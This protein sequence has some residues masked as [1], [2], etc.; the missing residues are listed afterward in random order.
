LP[1]AYGIFTEHSFIKDAIKVLVKA[2][3][4]PLLMAVYC[5]MDLQAAAASQGPHWRH[6]C[7]EAAAADTDM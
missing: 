2:S 1:L 5:T 4:V 3:T 6:G 7:S